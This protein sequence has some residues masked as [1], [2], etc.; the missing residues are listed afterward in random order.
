MIE[1]AIWRL[2]PTHQ[3]GLYC[4]TKS[5]ASARLMD[6]RSVDGRTGA[7]GGGSGALGR[8][9]L[10]EAEDARARVEAVVAGSVGAGASGGG[11]TEGA[12]VGDEAAATDGIVAGEGRNGSRSASAQATMTVMTSMGT[13]TRVIV[14]RSMR[15]ERVPVPSFSDGFERE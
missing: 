4:G 6:I 7:A 15:S 12:F 8:D 5:D 13:N 14:S 9:A 11:T 2:A 1:R 3:Y 10:V